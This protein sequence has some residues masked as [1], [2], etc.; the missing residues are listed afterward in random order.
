M[1]HE[2]SAA[3]PETTG[4]NADKGA[5]VA[6][7]QRILPAEAVLF[8]QEDLSPYE[9]DGLSA[10]R[11]LPLVVVI[12]DSI[13]EVQKVMRLCHSKNIPV[14]ARG[15]GTGLSGGAL[16]LAD[17]VVLSLA[18]LKSILH[19]D[20]EQ[21]IARVQPGV[22]NLAISEVAQPYG[23]Y[24]APDPSSQIACTIGGNIAENAGG[25]HCLSLIH[26]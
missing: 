12:P 6:A 1:N 2:H 3:S 11:Q 18:R 4:R 25:V 10:Y 16:P 19:V 5:L 24:Y 21:R 14:V 26:I 9:C 15:T 17:G 22:R 7:L 8:D 13:E 20:P 23:L